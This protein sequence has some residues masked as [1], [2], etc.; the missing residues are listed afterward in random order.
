MLVCASIVFLFP[1]HALRASSDVT[2]YFPILSARVDDPTFIQIGAGNNYT[3]AL[4]A[5]G[6]IECWGENYF[7]QLGDGTFMDREIRVAVTTLTSGV[8]AIHIRG[9]ASCALL[10]DGTVRCW[11][12][13]YD[14]QLGNGTTEQS[15][16]PVAVTGLANVS[17]I[18]GGDNHT[19]GVLQG[20]ALQCWG[21]N[22]SGQL[23]D[24]TKTNRTTPVAVAGLSGPVIQVSGG[25]DHTC[26]LLQNGGVQCWGKNNDGQLGN[27]SSVDSNSPVTV[28]GLVEPVVQIAGDYNFSCA[29]LQS[30]KIQCWGSRFGST[31]VTVKG[32]ESGMKAVALGGLSNR[33]AIAQNGSVT[34]SGIFND[35]GQLGNG[36]TQPTTELTPVGGISGGATAI[37]MGY[38]HGCALVN[39]QPLCWGANAQ[40]QLGVGQAIHRA[41]PSPVRSTTAFAQIAAGGTHTCSITT[42]GGVQCWGDSF[43]GQLGNKTTSYSGTPVDVV[44]LSSGIKQVSTGSEHSC[45]VTISGAV[46]CWGYNRDG[47]LG[48]GSTRFQSEVPVDVVGLS[49]GVQAVVVGGYFTCALTAAGGVKCWGANSSGELGNGSGTKSNVPVDVSGLQSGVT[50]LA[51]GL[52][53]VCALMASGQIMCWGDNY[54]GQLGDGTSSNERTTPVL[55][56]NLPTA[57]AVTSGSYHTCA[58]LTTGGVKCWGWNLEGELGDGT[59]EQRLN[60]VDVIGM[61]S[62]VQSTV[63]GQNHTCALTDG[64][65]VHCWGWNSLGQIGDGTLE[66]RVTPTA[67]LA[68]ASGVTALSTSSTHTCALLTSGAARCWGNDGDGE[69]GIGSPARRYSA[70][71]TV[72]E[73]PRELV[74]NYTTGKPGSVFTIS[75]FGYTPGENITLSTN[76]TALGL[77]LTVNP[78]GS[79]VA[80]LDTAG[81]DTGLYLITA[82][83]AQAAQAAAT[84]ADTAMI[85]LNTSATL[86]PQEG[87]GVPQRTVPA[88]IAYELHELFLPVVQR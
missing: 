30:G 73:R 38:D 15:N 78:S 42:A 35:K 22:G 52:R 47:Q 82:A 27:A 63:A 46:K 19:C 58:L 80:A 5:A 51:A 17:A 88:G 50:A 64:G 21:D 23:G 77:P 28:Q 60:P 25:R 66:A 68:L 48:S 61:T 87:G 72:D 53:Q 8:K 11:G 2:P 37:A 55:V 33:C 29:L 45:A 65:A 39:G 74:L 71:A 1:V 34:C 56:A 41:L 43:R 44:G 16:V 13:N 32:W 3:C 6:G 62:N 20:G 54:F 69:L 40:G 24:G 4:T 57:K 31:A 49:S 36:T 12:I 83:T 81:A 86:H 26:A 79:F 18:G 59:K 85:T 10:T 14:G 7:G 84:A 9:N 67:T 75:G 70:T 76:G